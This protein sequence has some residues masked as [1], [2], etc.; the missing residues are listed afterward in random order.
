MVHSND[1]LQDQQ[2]WPLAQNGSN[3]CLTWW[4]KSRPCHFGRKA[5]TQNQIIQ[6]G[7]WQERSSQSGHCYP[8]EEMLMKMGQI[9]GNPLNAGFKTRAESKQHS[10]VSE[11]LL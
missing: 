9:N 6:G 1:Q 8:N 2:Q 11:T 3:P 4:E 5:Q 7:S 10:A